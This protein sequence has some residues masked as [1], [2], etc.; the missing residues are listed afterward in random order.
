MALPKEMFYVKVK[1]GDGAKLRVYEKGGGVYSSRKFAQDRV[2]W[3][4]HRGVDCTLYTTG[5]IEWSPVVTEQP[6]MPGTE[7]FDLFKE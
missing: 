5:P 7:A 6:M 2:D 1:H 4:T 3:L